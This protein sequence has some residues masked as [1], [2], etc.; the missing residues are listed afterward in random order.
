MSK[1]KLP[2]ET[3]SFWHQTADVP[4]FPQLKENLHP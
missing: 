4:K 3:A 1:I 2:K